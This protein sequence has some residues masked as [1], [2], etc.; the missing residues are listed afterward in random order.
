[1]PYAASIHVKALLL[2]PLVP[3]TLR[4]LTHTSV[5]GRFHYFKHKLWPHGRR[6]HEMGNPFEIAGGFGGQ[7]ESFRKLFG[8]LSCLIPERP[9]ELLKFLLSC[10]LLQSIG[11]CN[12]GAGQSFRRNLPSRILRN[13]FD[14]FSHRDTPLLWAFFVLSPYF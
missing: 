1:M 9:I 3:G 12:V 4:R 5:F 14:R 11:N 6:S 2:P 10:S 7:S 8:S 13:R